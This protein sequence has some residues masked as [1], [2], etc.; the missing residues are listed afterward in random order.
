M[1]SFDSISVFVIRDTGYEQ[2]YK[3]DMNE[4][5]Y[6]QYM[7]EKLAEEGDVKMES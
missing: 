1:L 4:L 5:H 2:M 6:G 7:Q 3:G